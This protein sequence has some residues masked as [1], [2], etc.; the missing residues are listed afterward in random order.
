MPYLVA[1]N[2]AFP[3]KNNNLFILNENRILQNDFFQRIDFLFYS[4][5]FQ[6]FTKDIKLGTYKH[7]I[8]VF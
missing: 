1:G 7:K 5:Y 2:K 4:W 8:N 3:K 6:T